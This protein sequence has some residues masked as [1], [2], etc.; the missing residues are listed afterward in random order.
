MTGVTTWT[1]LVASLRRLRERPVLFVP[2]ALVGLLSTYVDA[3]RFSDPVPVTMRTWPHRGLV[4]LDVLVF[5]GGSRVAGVVP[6]A[7]LGLPTDLLVRVVVLSA[8]PLAAGV[9]ATGITVTVARYGLPKSV[10]GVPLVGL[11]RLFGYAAG[12]YVVATALALLAAFHALAG[13]LASVSLL[14]L[15]VRLFVAPPLVVL[16]SEGPLAAAFE[17]NRRTRSDDVSILGFVVVAGAVSYAL[18]S[19]PHVGTVLGTTVVGSVSAVATVVA[20]ERC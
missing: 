15:A 20:D 7:L 9:L 8:A 3:L 4:T 13:M 1:L 6:G 11:G 14:V 19:V 16:A 5:P 18:V 17:S 2:F 12:V 10:S